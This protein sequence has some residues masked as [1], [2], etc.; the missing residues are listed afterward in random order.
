MTDRL[1]LAHPPEKRKAVVDAFKQ[2]GSMRK[3]AAAVDLPKS[4]V[5][6]I[7]R[8]EGIE[9]APGGAAPVEDPQAEL[10]PPEI[11]AADAS[12]QEPQERQTPSHRFNLEAV[13][14]YANLL[15]NGVHPTYAEQAAKQIDP[16]FWVSP[17]ETERWQTALEQ[18][19]Y[20][21]RG[22]ALSERPRVWLFAEPNP[23]A[24]VR[25]I[26]GGWA[27][28]ETDIQQLTDLIEQVRL[29]AYLSGVNEQLTAL[30]RD[31]VLEISDP[32]VEARIRQDAEDAARQIADTYNRELAVKT[33]SSWLDSAAQQATVETDRVGALGQA[34]LTQRMREQAVSDDVAKWADDRAD[35]KS[36]SIAITEA[37][38][39]YSDGVMDFATQ[40]GGAFVH[41]E[42]DECVCDGCQELVDLGDIAVEDAA[43]IDL[44]LHVGCAH[45]LVVTYNPMDVPETDSM[46]LPVAA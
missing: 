34:G 28:D 7:L 33:G 45:S 10:L 29:D 38:A 44:P 22:M 26:Y 4:T 11:A 3:A 31:P 46:W 16:E 36:D 5:H 18:A 9:K 30:N 40:N 42:P 24:Y 20:D 15:A 13:Y 21:P 8:R 6:D 25:D 39:A 43:G 12:L 27:M 14:R 2:H 19:G 32:A 35:W 23:P 17:E 1:L 41:V 37:N